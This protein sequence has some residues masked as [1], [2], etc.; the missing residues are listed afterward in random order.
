[1]RVAVAATSAS[2]GEEVAA[3]EC[4]QSS[5]GCTLDV[6]E[7]RTLHGGSDIV[8]ELAQACPGKVKVPSCGVGESVP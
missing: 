5:G 8:R 6:H 1:M 4:A 3:G 2:L 7:L